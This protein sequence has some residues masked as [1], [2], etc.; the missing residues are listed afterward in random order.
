MR[1]GYLEIR[2]HV[3]EELKAGFILGDLDFVEEVK[4]QYL[5]NIEKVEDL[6]ELRRLQKEY[7]SGDKILEILKNMP[8]SEKFINLLFEEIYRQFDT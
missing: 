5:N 2:G 4:K 8:E 3:F 6:P 1:Q 7:I